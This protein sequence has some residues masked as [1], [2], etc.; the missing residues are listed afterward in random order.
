M[1]IDVHSRDVVEHLASQQVASAVDFSW[2]AVLRYQWDE[3]V[4][5]LAVRQSS[6][7]FEYGYEYLGAQP[8]LV[9][10]PMT[11]RWAPDRLRPGASSV[12]AWLAPG[13]R[14]VG[15]AQQGALLR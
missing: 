11:D 15:L 1:T 7:S 2:Q 4:E 9:A 8:R 14:L 13:W 10:T 5:G 12:L 6:A 3:A